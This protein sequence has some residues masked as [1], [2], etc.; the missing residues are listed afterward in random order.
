MPTLEFG[1]IFT[2]TLSSWREILISTPMC[3]LTSQPGAFSHGQNVHSS[4]LRVFLCFSNTNR[5]NRNYLRRFVLCRWANM[6][7]IEDSAAPGH[8]LSHQSTV[9]TPRSRFEKQEGHSHS[10]LRADYRDAGICIF[11]LHWMPRT[12]LLL[13]LPSRPPGQTQS[14]DHP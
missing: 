2:G 12:L 8:A 11:R 6:A 14:D 9:G 4:R 10:Y 7:T 13:C 1:G 3:V 5:L